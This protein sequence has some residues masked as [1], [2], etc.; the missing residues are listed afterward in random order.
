[1]FLIRVADSRVN[2]GIFI[3]KK[4]EALTAFCS[5]VRFKVRNLRRTWAIFV[6]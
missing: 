4:L 3:L 2:L 5:V 6:R 1:M